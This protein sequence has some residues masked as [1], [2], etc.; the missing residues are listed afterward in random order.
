METL[1]Q[2]DDHWIVPL[3]EEELSDWIASRCGMLPRLGV[4]IQSVDDLEQLGVARVTESKEDWFLAVYRMKEGKQARSVPFSRVKLLLAMTEHKLALLENHYAGFGPEIGLARAEQGAA[5]DIW[6]RKSRIETLAA[7]CEEG[8]N[9]LAEIMGC[10]RQVKRSFG[11]RVAEVL[12]ADELGISRVEIPACLFAY[13]R[14]IETGLS[15]LGAAF[16]DLGRVLRMCLS[17]ERECEV[18]K[19]AHHVAETFGGGR[20]IGPNEVARLLNEFR[21]IKELKLSF[22]LFLKWKY[23][24]ER[25][26][27]MVDFK[28]LMADLAWFKGVKGVMGEVESGILL[29]GAFVGFKSFA[30]QYHLYM[31]EK[32]GNGARPMKH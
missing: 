31:K 12:V 24:A 6:W 7:D 23:A 11:R 3:T 19:L 13:S 1:V 16:C 4:P 15:S 20:E 8:A 29:Y 22:V 18:S 21:S 10:R 5:F 14:S 32:N 27:G 28:E 30:I 26:G 17:E 25:N 2:T 9:G